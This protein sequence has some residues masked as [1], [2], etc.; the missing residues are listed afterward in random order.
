MATSQRKRKGYRLT[1]EEQIRT[2]GQG[3]RQDAIP[4]K[5]VGEPSG[6]KSYCVENRAVSLR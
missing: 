4:A 6:S 2:V 1:G 3:R 5:S